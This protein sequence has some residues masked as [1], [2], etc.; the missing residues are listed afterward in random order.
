M[1]SPSEAER[2]IA[3]AASLARWWRAEIRAGNV[4]PDAATAEWIL[5]D[6]ETI[7]RSQ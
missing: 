4:T 5:R 6:L 7:G 3:Q 2:R 1:N